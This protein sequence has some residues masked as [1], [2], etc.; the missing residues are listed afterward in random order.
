[1]STYDP[2]T[3]LTVTARIAESVPEM[4]SEF[5]AATQAM[6]EARHLAFGRMALRDCYGSLSFAELAGREEFVVE[7]CHLTRNRFRARRSGSAWA[8]TS[9]SALAGAAGVPGR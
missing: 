3:T 2:C 8:S 9:R 1:M 5:Y 4:D 6:D 7:G